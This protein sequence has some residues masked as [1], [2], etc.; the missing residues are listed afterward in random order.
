MLKHLKPTLRCKKRIVPF[1]KTKFTFQKA[2]RTVH[3]TY[4]PNSGTG[5]VA[6]F[7]ISINDFRLFFFFILYGFFLKSFP[8][9]KFKKKTFCINNQTFLSSS[10]IWIH[11]HKDAVA[12]W[13]IYSYVRFRA[14]LICKLELIV[15]R[16]YLRLNISFIRVRHICCR[17]Q[18]VSIFTCRCYK[19]ATCSYSVK[20]KPKDK[21]PIQSVSVQFSYKTATIYILR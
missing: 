4:Q 13:I 12:L 17:D 19:C 8:S 16:K 21:P 15:Y 10:Y 14:K 6:R 3:K 11:I 18:A 2:N 9:N 7:R 20:W 1:R 5:V